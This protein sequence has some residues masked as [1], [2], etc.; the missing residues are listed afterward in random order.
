MAN[1]STYKIL[2]VIE[3][4]SN[5]SMRFRNLVA[6]ICLLKKKLAFSNPLFYFA[7]ISGAMDK[8]N[9]KR[10]YS[11]WMNQYVGAYLYRDVVKLFPG[12]NEN[13]FRMFTQFLAGISGDVVNYANVARFLGV[14]QPT[15]RDYFEIAYGTFLWRTIPAY[16]QNADRR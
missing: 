11:L 7:R 4:S 15:A 6:N 3:Y 2:S 16:T 10:F 8:K 13:R 14:S 5:V 9:S 1:L 12:I